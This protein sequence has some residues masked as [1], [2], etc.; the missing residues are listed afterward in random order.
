MVKQLFLVFGLIV[1]ISGFYIR[2]E[3]RN[4]HQL[5][6]IDWPYTL[7]GDGDWSID[8]FTLNQAPKRNI[9]D[10]ITVVRYFLI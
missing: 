9:K 2:N 4:K 7:C 10:A 6:D 8:K 1:A 5:E 3:G